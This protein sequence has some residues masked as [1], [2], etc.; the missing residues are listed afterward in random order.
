MLTAQ[1]HTVGNGQKIWFA[2][3]DGKM[4]RDKRGVG[5]RFKTEQAALRAATLA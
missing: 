5:R 1:Q 3:V 4:L 2:Y